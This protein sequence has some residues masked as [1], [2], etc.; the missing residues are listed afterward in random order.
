MCLDTPEEKNSTYKGVAVL[1]MAL[2]GMQ[3]PI[4]NEMILRSL[5][6]IL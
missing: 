5:N 6:H 3:D 2:I 4:G 1:S